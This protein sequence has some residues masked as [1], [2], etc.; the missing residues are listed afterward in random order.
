ME[1]ARP[2]SDLFPRMGA[3]MHT[4]FSAVSALGGFLVVLIVGTAWRLGSAR[5]CA[6]N[7]AELRNL[8]AAMSFQY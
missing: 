4:H 8:G 1:Y 5:L 2:V 7:R 3:E 6:S